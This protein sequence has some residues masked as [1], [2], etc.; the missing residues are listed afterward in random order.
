MPD[1]PGKATITPPPYPLTMSQS[2]ESLTPAKIKTLHALGWDLR[3]PRA[4]RNP[5][6]GIPRNPE[7][8]KAPDVKDRRIFPIN[9]SVIHSGVTV[10]LSESE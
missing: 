4:R 1:P 6:E 3:K 9:P 7:G 5:Y 8:E 10:P 2:G